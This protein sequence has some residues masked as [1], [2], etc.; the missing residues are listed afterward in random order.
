MNR[1]SAIILALILGIAVFACGGPPQPQP[2]PK[3]AVA[4][5]TQQPEAAPANSLTPTQPPAE[6][7]PA[8]EPPPR[9]PAA[10]PRPSET[11]PP[12]Q[13]VR[14]QPVRT[15]PAPVSRPEPVERPNPEN[16][17]VYE[18]PTDPAPPAN[19]GPVIVPS[20]PRRPEEYPEVVTV[21]DN[22][23]SP[24]PSAVRRDQPAP[25]QVKVVLREGTPIEVRMTENLS[26]SRNQNGDRFEA[27]L[28]RNLEVDGKLV[29]RKG[30]R[31]IGHLEGV[32]P[33][34]RVKGRAEMT[35]R[36]E[37]IVAGE[38]SISL[39]TN[40]I[41]IQAESGTTKDAK[42][43]GVAAGIG[44]AIGAIA[45]GKKGAAIGAAIGGGAGTAK[46]LTSRG[47]DASVEKEQLLSFRLEKDVEVLTR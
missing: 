18:P 33:G 20:P 45:G 4:P 35:L 12:R 30:D 25:R 27:I 32:D 42:T 34:G 26:S 22:E 8:E 31:V 36:W 7:P 39:A 2:E 5:A 1:L 47:E 6:E 9:R 37:R 10:K 23:P 24:P 15:Q 14:T 21:P 41:T 44:A 38:N 28:D 40:P 46:V 19:T 3:A 13:P 11:T 16:A 29:A 17:E 43:V